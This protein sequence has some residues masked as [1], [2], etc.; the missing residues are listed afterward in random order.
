MSFC[1]TC[2]A[3]LGFGRFCTN[4]G[5]PLP[6][7]EETPDAGSDA[8]Q[9]RLPRVQPDASTGP[10]FPLYADETDPAPAPRDTN[11]AGI[12]AVTDPGPAASTASTYG[13]PVYGAAYGPPPG[14]PP[15]PTAQ[16]YP[17]AP[18]PPPQS[19]RRSPWPWVALT[20][21]L[22]AGVGG[23]A[24]ALTRGDDSPQA[25]QASGKESS[26]PSESGSTG[27]G[28]PS[29]S[30]SSSPG[31][32]VPVEPDGDP[33]DLAT[34]A[35]VNAPTPRDP[36]MDVNNNEVRF[37]AS[38]MLDRDPT[39]SYQ[40]TGDATGSV[41]TFSFDAPVTVHEVGLINGY[42]KREGGNNWYAKNRK[43]MQVE[44]AFDDGSSIQ[45]DLRQTTDLQ[46]TPVSAVETRTIRLTLLKVSK[47]GRADPR[48]YTAISSVLLR[49]V[50]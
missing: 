12:P 41:I 44:W 40:I 8:T 7:F 32:T 9:V 19:Q 28:G 48:N 26:Q 38:N 20:L 33:V 35:R 21:V 36:G 47:P 50:H 10:R 18:P 5:T 29:E 14:P 2:G 24:W 43:I 4:C 16:P 23:G 25:A 42:A 11:P 3:Q 6:S 30:Q 22:L 17:T 39:T 13:T 27:S 49:G 15:M 46:S 1:T 37:P 34:Q 31:P 45:Q